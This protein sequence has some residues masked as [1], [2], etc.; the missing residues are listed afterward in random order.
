[1]QT[2]HVS[3]HS[4]ECLDAI[5]HFC[6]YPKLAGNALSMELLKEILQQNQ[7]IYNI[8]GLTEVCEQLLMKK[9]KKRGGKQEGT[10]T[11]PR[12]L[13]DISFEYFL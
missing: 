10:P 7:Q 11:R 8:E 9:E 4:Y 3:D 13:K 5:L 6:Y 2:I 1:M 12:S